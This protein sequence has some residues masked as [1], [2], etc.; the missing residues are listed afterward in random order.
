MVATRRERAAGTEA[1]L[2]AAALRLF[3]ERGYLNTKITDITAAAGRA[4]GS[5]YNHFTGKQELLEALFRDM[6]AESDD[7]VAEHPAEHDLSDPAVLRWHVAGF[8]HAF[9]RYRPV[10]VAMTHAAMVDERAAGRLRELLS[11]DRTAIRAHMEY[12]VAKG[13]ELPGPPDAVAVAMTAMWFQ[14][15]YQ[16]LVSGFLG[17]AGPLG[18]DEAIDLLTGFTLRG[19]AGTVEAPKRP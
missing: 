18:D 9:R 5:F 4:A 19:L 6:L 3:D 13:I 16:Q 7:A 10:F 14:F 11:P 17:P 12:L 8:W 1:A 2:K 15:A